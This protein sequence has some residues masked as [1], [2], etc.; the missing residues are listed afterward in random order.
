M[1]FRTDGEKLA[2]SEVHRFGNEPVTKDGALRWDLDALFAE[3]CAGMEKAR[4]AGGFESVGVDTWG[5]DFGLLG[6]DGGLLEPPVHYRD[7]RTNGLSDE[8]CKALGER[9]LYE[10]TGTQRMDI[11]TL[12]QLYAL[13]KRRPELLAQAGCLLLMP[14][15][16]AWLLTGERRAELTIA[17]TTQMLDLNSRVWNAPL[18][19]RLGLPG[20]ILPPL[21]APG[22]RTGVLRKELREKLGVPAVPVAAVASHDTASAVLAV[23]A[24]EEDFL[25][26]SCGTWSLFGTERAEPVITGASF[27]CNL[28]NEL[29][30]GGKATLLKNITGLWLIQETRRQFLR[31][32]RAYT[33]AQMEE[34]ARGGRPFLCFIDLD[35]PEFVPA[36]DI[37]GRIREFCRETGQYIPQSDGEILRCIYESLALK[38]RDALG[39]IKACTGG[40][41]GTVYLVGGGARDGLLC[42]M[43][44]DAMGL[45]V[46]AGPVEATAMGN[47]AAQFV[48]L[49]VFGGLKEARAAV[50]RSFEPKR[51]LPAQPGAWSARYERIRPFLAKR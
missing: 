12:F 35:A 6:R 1:L 40:E 21:A 4:D 22:T 42:Q 46:V 9:A 10:A 20:E 28:T 29:G 2:L 26:V 14:D 19:D 15:L 27:A 31:E 41:Y 44:A 25:F 3:M 7:P 18:L 23:P 48:A 45:P 38:Y 49:G 37:P 17:S 30:F 32:G 24:C 43:T 16:F 51:Y 11:N 8:V 33:Y 39:Q 47:A 36:G 50:R 5:V 13:K 34:T